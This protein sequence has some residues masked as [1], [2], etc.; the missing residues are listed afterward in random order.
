MFTDIRKK[1]GAAASE[2]DLTAAKAKIAG[3]VK[4]AKDLAADAAD[5]VSNRVSNPADAYDEALDAVIDE[6]ENPEFAGLGLR[7][8]VDKLRRGNPYR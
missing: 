8:L 3:T 7:G 6:G 5:T 4:A 2:I 1:L